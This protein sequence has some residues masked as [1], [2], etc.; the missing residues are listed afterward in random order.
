MDFLYGLFPNNRKDTFLR[1]KMEQ[2][3]I[4]IQCR[5]CDAILKVRN[6]SGIEDKIVVCPMCKQRAYFSAYRRLSQSHEYENKVLIDSIM[7]GH[8]IRAEERDGN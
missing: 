4:R 7:H 8:F 1:L 5:S 6:C 3:E 2:D